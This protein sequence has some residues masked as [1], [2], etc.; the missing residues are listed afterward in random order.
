MRIVFGLEIF[1]VN[2]KQDPIKAVVGSYNSND[3]LMY[4]ST[5]KV[6]KLKIDPIYIRKGS[7]GKHSI[8]I[9]SLAIN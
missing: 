2:V 7:M 5:P 3:A 1:H 8:Y 4:I 6:L 9:Y